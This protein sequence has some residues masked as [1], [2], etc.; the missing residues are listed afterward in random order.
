[1]YW[2]MNILL[3]REGGHLFSGWVSC[4]DL[5]YLRK[6]GALKR[7][8]GWRLGDSV[9]RR[10]TCTIEAIIPRASQI[11]SASSPLARRLLINHSTTGSRCMATV[12]GAAVSVCGVLLLPLKSEIGVDASFT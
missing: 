8:R 3:S 1:M 2:I 9:E 6:N 12:A 10:C 5:S 4:E 7:K 11:L